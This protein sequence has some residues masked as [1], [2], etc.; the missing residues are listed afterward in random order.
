MSQSLE[1]I[2]TRNVTLGDLAAAARAFGKPLLHYDGR[3]NLSGDTSDAPGE[4]NDVAFSFGCVGRLAVDFAL[5][6]GTGEFAEPPGTVVFDVKGCAQIDEM[7]I[8]ATCRAPAP[9]S[10][11]QLDA[12]LSAIT[13]AFDA[14]PSVIVNRGSLKMGPLAPQA[15]D[16]AEDVND[17]WGFDVAAAMQAYTVPDDRWPEA[18]DERLFECWRC[19]GF[20]PAW[21]FPGSYG[22]LD[23]SYYGVNRVASVLARLVLGGNMTACQMCVDDVTVRYSPMRPRKRK[24]E[25]GVAVQPLHTVAHP[26]QG[27]HAGRWMM[28]VQVMVKGHPVRCSTFHHVGY[29]D[30]LF[31]S[32]KAAAAEY[33]AANPHMRPIRKESD[34]TSDWDPVSRRRFVIRKVCNVERTL[35]CPW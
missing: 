10:A 29:I 23:D 20:R 6:P 34:W 14:R 1:V 2:A 3:I 30:K 28:E 11:A 32:R 27:G 4:R 17:F 9:L 13:T 16:S 33:H 5:D 15:T 26:Q 8:T 25:G 21:H 18:D 12:L 22:K 31:G 7:R 35:A 24:A 19:A